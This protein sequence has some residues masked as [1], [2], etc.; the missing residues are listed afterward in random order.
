MVPPLG[1]PAWLCL[2]TQSRSASSYKDGFSCQDSQLS[3]SPA[4]AKVPAWGQE[5]LT[6]VPPREWRAGAGCPHTR[7]GSAGSRPQCTDE[8]WQACNKP[9][10]TVTFARQP[11]AG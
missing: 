7:A 1:M 9:L 11:L 6:L 5:E 4:L 10:V 2:A 8:M 3:L